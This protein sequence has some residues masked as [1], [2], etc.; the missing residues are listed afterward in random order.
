MAPT[1][2]RGGRGS[3]AGRNGL[4]RPVI[5]QRSGGTGGK[6]GGGTPGKPLIGKNGVVGTQKPAGPGVRSAKSYSGGKTTNRS[7][8]SGVRQAFKPGSG[9]GSSGAAGKPPKKR[10]DER[11]LLPNE[12]GEYIWTTSGTTV[13]A[14]ITGTDWSTREHTRGPAAELRADPRKAPVVDERDI[15]ER[16]SRKD[17]PQDANQLWPIPKG[18]PGVIKAPKPGTYDDDW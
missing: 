2:S 13:P 11:G 17:E 7:V 4:N 12:G 1:D 6:P 9:P 16:L 14:V 10:E 5:G 18:T 3:A 8:V 15:V